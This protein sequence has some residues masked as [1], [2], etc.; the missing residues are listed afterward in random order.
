M[1]KIIASLSLVAAIICPAFAHTDAVTTSS[2]AGKDIQFRA[3]ID[4]EQMASLPGSVNPRLEQDAI[5]IGG[6]CGINGMNMTD[7]QL[8]KIAKL[9]G[10]F[11]DSSGAKKLQAKTLSRQ[12]RDLMSQEKI[13]RA[14]VID[15]QK[16]I[17][18]IHAE[19]ATSRLSM[20][21]DALDVLTTEQRKKINSMALKRQVFGSMGGKS[22]RG[23]K[24]GG[25]AGHHGKKFGAGRRSQGEAPATGSNNSEEGAQANPST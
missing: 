18:D 17:S 14:Q 4:P 24:H 23:G 10:A 13:D 12:L 11:A 15:L 19:L 20:R 22:V 8:E 21:I 1:K 6:A 7:E 2:G 25:R 16:K 9:K 5:G 3:S